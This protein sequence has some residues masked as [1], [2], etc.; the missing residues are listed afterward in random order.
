MQLSDNPIVFGAHERSYNNPE[1]RVLGKASQVAI[2]FLMDEV[3]SQLRFAAESWSRRFADDFTARDLFEVD[4]W[5]ASRK[6]GG[7][8]GYYVKALSLAKILLG[9]SGLSTEYLHPLQAEGV[10]I[11][12]ATLFE[13]FVRKSLIESY[14]GQGIL[15]TKGGGLGIQS[16]YTDGYFELDPDFVFQD[17]S[18]ILLIADA[19]YKVPDSKDHYQ[20]ICY[21][22]RYKVRT[23]VIFMPCFADEDSV[24][25]M[26]RHITPDGTTVWEVAL[27]LDDLQVTESILADTLKRFASN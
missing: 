26:V 7:S 25:P 27:P 9:Q 18:T 24:S 11:N 13:T 19:K 6:L 22:N 12:T 8:R 1:N 15:V 5:L 3:N 20:I 17:R 14:K 16:L 23:G 21:L 10:L 4:R 2:P